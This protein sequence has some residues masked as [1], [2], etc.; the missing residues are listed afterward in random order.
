MTGE[1]HSGGAMGGV[2]MKSEW[3]QSQDHI[4]PCESLCPLPS[5]PTELEGH[6]RQLCGG[7]NKTEA[8]SSMFGTT[9]VCKL[10]FSTVYFMKDK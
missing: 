4:R 7:L 6:P 2:Q 8:H 9:W 10:T 1:E 5:T 3:T